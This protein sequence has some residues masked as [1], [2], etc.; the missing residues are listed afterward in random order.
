MFYI[1]LFRQH[2]RIWS[3]LKHQRSK[4][5]Q[6][7]KPLSGDRLKFLVSVMWQ[8]LIGILSMKSCSTIELVANWR[9]VDIKSRQE[10]LKIWITLH[11]QIVIFTMFSELTNSVEH[12]NSA[13]MKQFST[14]LI[15][16][17]LHMIARM[18]ETIHIIFSSQS[19]KGEYQNLFMC[20]VWSQCERMWSAHFGGQW[21]ENSITLFDSFISSSYM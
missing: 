19:A 9:S 5:H 16:I 10:K 11:E 18:K 3:A 13:Q 20:S 21:Q 1:W 4:L 12:Y 15:C 8:L 7:L 6:G 14:H 2:V 17:V